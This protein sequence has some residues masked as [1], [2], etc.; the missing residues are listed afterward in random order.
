LTKYEDMQVSRKV[1]PPLSLFA[2]R[3]PVVKRLRLGAC[4]LITPRG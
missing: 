4:R 2:I 3:V 1:D